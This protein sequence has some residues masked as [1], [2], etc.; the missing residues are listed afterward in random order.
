MAF[1]GLDLVVPVAVQRQR[2]AGEARQ[3][4]IDLLHLAV[5]VA[6]AVIFVDVPVQL[7]RVFLDIG[8]QCVRYVQGAWIEAP[9]I[10]RDLLHIDDLLRRDGHRVGRARTIDTKRWTRRIAGELLVVGEE[11]QRVL[12][13]RAAEGDAIGFFIL[14]ASKGR[15]VGVVAHPVIVAEHVVH[16]TAEL[17]GARLGDGV[18]DAAGGAGQG[19]VVFSNRDR[20]SLGWKVVR[21]QTKRIVGGDAVDLDGVEAGV[22]TTHR[23]FA[24]LLVGLRHARVKADI[25]LDV[26]ANRRQRA[27]LRL[28]DIGAGA[29]LVG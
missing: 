8:L 2:A 12:D 10:C 3:H 14:E 28:A 6:G 7:D 24:A 22:L 5:A 13:Q 18:D 26:A 29:H 27:D 4:R 9:D 15:S 20:L 21:L 16:R 23:D 17:V 25:V 19:G 1:E 11:E